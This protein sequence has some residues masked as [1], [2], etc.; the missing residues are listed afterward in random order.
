M[1]RGILRKTGLDPSINS[2]KRGK[3]LKCPIKKKNDYNI[4]KSEL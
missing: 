2:I 1:N 4:S 3:L